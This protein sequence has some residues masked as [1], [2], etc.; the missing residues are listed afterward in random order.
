MDAYYGW[1][2]VA[3]ALVLMMTTPALALF[4]G[5]MTRA[6]SVLNMMMMSYVAMGTVGISF[7]L[8]G[9]SEGG[10]AG[11]NKGFNNGHLIANPFSLFGLHTEL[12]SNY[13]YVLFQLT[14][15]VIT[16]ALIS[17]SIA[18]RVKIFPWA[19]FSIL[20]VTIVYYP[21][22]HNVWGGGWLYHHFANL[23]YA[24]GTVVHINAGI[25]GGVL[26][27][28]IGKRIGFKKDPMK[29]HN[30]TLTMVGAGLLWFGWY[31]FN[32][33]SIVLNADP[34]AGPKETA[35]Q[36]AAYASSLSAQFQAETGATFLNTTIA[37]MAAMIAWLLVE[38]LVH[39]KFTSLGAASGIV[40]GLVAITPSCG[41]VNLWGAIAV[42]AI[43]G[44]VC[45]VAVG[46]KYKIGL[47]DSLDVVG[48]HLT[49]GILG[50]LL[51][52]FVGT[53]KG[54]PQGADGLFHDAF[55]NV[56][57]NGLFYGGNATLLYHQFAGVL[58]TLI[59]SGVGTAIIA[60]AIKYT[61]GWR[62]KPEAEIEGI[63]GDQHG[64][65][66]YD[67]APGSGVLV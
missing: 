48:V 57:M 7:V 49:G 26:A 58:F 37:T 61:I 39:K 65:Q 44:A 11:T 55:H 52:G 51:I 64:E 45:A 23:D 35:D 22:A 43:A 53:A 12:P 29:P 14:F 30:L 25:A 16:V 24:G 54:S 6:K 13:I 18:D 28:I 4:Y 10:W 42:G 8:W 3:T 66:A 41:A 33:G 60:L 1:M 31:G 62:V 19:V 63:D 40:A 32:V 67:V 20:W 59:W 38:R 56:D 46:F 17:G 50:A 21:I 2:I 36:A 15:A 5:G 47:D 9:W 27:L 34:N